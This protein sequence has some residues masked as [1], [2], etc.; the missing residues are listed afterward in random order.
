MKHL[1]AY[2]VISA[3]VALI[4]ILPLLVKRHPMLYSLSVFLQCLFVGIIIFCLTLPWLPWWA[5]GPTVAFCLALPEALRPAVKGG[6]AWYFVLLNALVAGFCFAL[7][8]HYLPAMLA[9]LSAAA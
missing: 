4:D 8:K 2:F 6:Y 9:F 3:L 5:Q 7:V 1:L